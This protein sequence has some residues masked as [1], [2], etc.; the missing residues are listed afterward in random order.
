LLILFLILIFR[1]ISIGIA[2]KDA[3]GRYLAIGVATMILFQV[4]INVGMNIGIMPVT[5]IPLPL[6][7]HGGSSLFSIMIALGIVGSVFL[8]RKTITFE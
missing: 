3:L 5:G 2:A 4:L 1:I 6:I 8:R 7:S